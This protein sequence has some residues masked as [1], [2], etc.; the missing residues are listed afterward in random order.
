MCSQS[1]H[2]VLCVWRS[3]KSYVLWI[4]Y[5]FGPSLQDL[6]RALLKAARDGRTE[7]VIAFLDQGVDIEATDDVVRHVILLL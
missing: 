5:V 2:V 7:E 3:V 4:N 6:G 1:L